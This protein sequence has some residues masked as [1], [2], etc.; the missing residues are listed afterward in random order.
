MIYYCK[1]NKKV[2]EFKG[3]RANDRYQ[4]KDGNFIL[5]QADILSIGSKLGMSIGKD[6]LTKFLSRVCEQI[7]AVLLTIDQTKEEQDGT[8]TTAM[9]TPLDDR[10]K[11][12]NTSYSNANGVTDDLSVNEES[13]EPAGDNEG[14]ADEESDE[15]VKPDNEGEA[16]S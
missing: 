9:P 14:Q 10:F 16:E 3:F 15:D 12:D 13:S 2:W 6:G 8:T 1:A 11:M 7:G 4:L 5:W